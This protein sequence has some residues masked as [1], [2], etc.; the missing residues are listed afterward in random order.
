MLY[1]RIIDEEEDK[2]SYSLWSN[3][4]A[5]IANYHITQKKKSIEDTDLVAGNVPFTERN[6]CFISNDYLNTLKN[7][8]IKKESWLQSIFDNYYWRSFINYTHKDKEQY[9]NET[10]EI[11]KKVS[12]NDYK[13]NI[14]LEIVEKF[15]VI[16]E[17]L[18]GIQNYAEHNVEYRGFD[19]KQ[20]LD[21]CLKIPNEKLEYNYNNICDTILL[22]DNDS[23]IDKILKNEFY[24]I[25]FVKN[26]FEHIM[27]YLINHFEDEDDT[28]KYQTAKILE[29]DDLLKIQGIKKNLLNLKFLCLLILKEEK[30][31][32]YNPNINYELFIRCSNDL[33]QKLSD[34]VKRKTKTYFYE[35]I[36]FL[37]K[38]PEAFRIIHSYYPYNDDSLKK[39]ELK[40]SNYYIYI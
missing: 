33:S 34:L 12:N 36:L 24:Q 4:C 22:L 16:N 3:L 30:I 38:Y 11:I 26:N 6:L 23:K 20:F 32:L 13:I 1:N 14:Q 25:K 18:I 19:F 29:N 15:K 2:S 27:N 35:L 10:L 9:K 7:S 21:K 31:E 39:G 8:S 37:V 40:Y 17:F 28:L 5:R